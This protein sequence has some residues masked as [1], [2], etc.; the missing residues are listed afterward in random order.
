[1]GIGNTAAASAIVAAI[2]GRAVAEVTG[3]GTGVD[4]EGWR[5]K[6]AVIER[7]LAL[8]RP[9]PNDP[10]GVLA[11][12]GGFEIGGLAGV[13]LGAAARRVPVVLDGFIAGAAALLA[14]DLAPAL[15][16]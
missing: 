11:A 13:M 12:V 2:T 4:D 8:H 15:A 3:R 6:V 7:A 14:V 10:L 9:D 16:P 1:M 5:R